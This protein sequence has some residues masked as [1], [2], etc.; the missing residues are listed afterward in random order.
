MGTLSGEETVSVLFLFSFSR[1]VNPKRKEFAPLGAEQILSFKGKHFS[2]SERVLSSREAN[3]ELQGLFP[4]VK[5]PK[6]MEM[7]QYTFSQPLSFSV[8]V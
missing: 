5:M 7:Y 4:L 1:K 3:R 8:C 6:K 2:L